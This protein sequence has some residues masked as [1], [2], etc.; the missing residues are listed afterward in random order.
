MGALSPV[1][2][3]ILHQGGSSPDFKDEKTEALRCD[4]TCQDGTPPRR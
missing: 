4:V 2:L 1:T 3:T